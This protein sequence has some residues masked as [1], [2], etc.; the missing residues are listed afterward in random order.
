MI[1]TLQRYTTTAKT[2]EIMARYRPIAPK[3]ESNPN[4]SANDSNQLPQN[5]R[6]SA[7]LRN[8]W[9]HLQARPTRTRKRGRTG[10]APC[11]GTT[12][13][14]KRT[15]TATEA[16]QG[17]ILSPSPKTLTFQ[18]FSTHNNA[19]PQLSCIRNLVPLKCSLETPISTSSSLVTL[20]LLP[21]TASLS[22]ISITQ[23][24]LSQVPSSDGSEKGKMGID[25]NKVADVPEEL[26]FM[27]QLQVAEKPSPPPTSPGVITPRAVR[28]VCSTIIIN[29][30]TKESMH[31]EGVVKQLL[32]KPD[33]V[34]KEVEAQDSPVIISDS[35]NKVRL[36]NSAYKE[37][38]GQPE[39][40][41]LDFT[42][43]CGS[44]RRIGG[45]VLVQFLEEAKIQN[46]SSNGFACKAKI[47]WESNGKKNSV[48]A[49]CEVTKLACS[50]KDYVSK[51][52]FHLNKDVEGPSSCV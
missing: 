43:S 44:R 4:N 15:R 14:T 24:K 6:K 39:C 29:C 10:F 1:Q 9:P 52:M 22:L 45:E 35:N 32:K 20:P 5:I 28:P 19:L 18:G 36:E 51:W 21:C 37:L 2:A 12:S 49:F 8:V 31:E 25:L 33:E 50:N 34:E 47:E 42:P 23:Q 30:I 38:V 46:S 17:G 7:Y 3:P 16:I 26:D 11:P 13:S 41:W 40:S 27:Q 48:G